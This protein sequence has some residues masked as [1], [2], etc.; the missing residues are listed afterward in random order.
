MTEP[1]EIIL[2]APVVTDGETL[3]FSIKRQEDEEVI[4]HRTH[5]VNRILEGKKE[6]YKVCLK[7]EYIDG[8]GSLEETIL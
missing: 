3:K 4:G 8:N 5:V 7:T 6:Y 2:K 1:K